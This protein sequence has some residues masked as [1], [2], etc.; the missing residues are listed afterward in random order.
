MF[1]LAENLHRRGAENAE[2]RRGGQKAFIKFFSALPC[3]VCVLC[4]SAVNLSFA[5]S[6]NFPNIGRT[7]TPQEIQAWDIDV[8]PDFKGLPAGQGSVKQGEVL[9]DAQCQ[10]CHGHFGESS[11]FFTPIA[12][13][14]T[15]EDIKTGRVKSLAPGAN[16]PQRTTLMKLSSL[17][18]LWDYINR[19]MPWNSPK[20]L[21]SDEVYAATAY[22]LHLGNILPADFVL[23][24]RNMSAVQAILPNRL[25][26]TTV[27]GMWPGSEL[28]GGTSPM[29]P[30]VQGSSCMRDCGPDVSVK[31]TLP[32]YAKTAHGNL[33]DQSRS[34]G[35]S[36]GLVTSAVKVAQDLTKNDAP[37][38]LIRAQ[39]APEIVATTTPLKLS[40]IKPLLDKN[41]CTACHGLEN[42]LVGPSFK[43]IA[44][45]YKTQ[46]GADKLLEGKIKNGSQ[47][48]WGVVPMPAQALSVADASQIAQWLMAGM[49]E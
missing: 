24:N 15:A 48:V 33:A 7:A 3:F 41:N 21:S 40:Q 46:P 36:R 44:A 42:K 29:K 20:S 2:L 26:K 47:G 35:P 38:Q 45:R 9:W 28:G 8:R 5:Q 39:A 12:G 13:G 6:G 22:I 1:K 30:D 31:S 43:D 18:T 32:D 11:E 25:G 23:S 10:S 17:S 37:A 14:T 27:H 19:A 16:Q 4:A 34:M 49:P